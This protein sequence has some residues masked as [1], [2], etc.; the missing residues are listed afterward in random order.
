[1]ETWWPVWLGFSAVQTLLLAWLLVV[2]RRR[3]RESMTTLAAHLEPVL[4]R[5]FG[6]LEAE[7]E[8]LGQLADEAERMVHDLAKLI[9]RTGAGDGDPA[10]AEDL[11]TRNSRLEARR[12]LADG[13][14][15]AA[16]SE[17]TGLP[18]GEVQVLANLRTAKSFTPAGLK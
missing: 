16:V 9:G 3:E 11:R 17:A 5:M 8:R 14:D 4:R 1:M 12:L 7:R 2:G 18:L 6:Q 10:A 13:L 15:P